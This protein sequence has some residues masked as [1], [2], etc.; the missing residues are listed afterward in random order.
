MTNDKEA[1]YGNPPKDHRFTPGKSGNPRGRPKGARNM[2]TDLAKMMKRK[3]TVRENGRPRRI[4]RQ[5]AMLL[6]LYDKALHG[7]VRAAM[8]IINMMLIIEPAARVDIASEKALSDI[9]KNIVAD[10]LRRNQSITS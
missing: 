2:R 4:S 10:F 7:D 8:S 3:V 1:G 5:E 9:D 6:S